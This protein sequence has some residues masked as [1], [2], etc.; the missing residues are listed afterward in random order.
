MGDSVATLLLE[1]CEDD[2]HTPEME[3]KESTGTPE[4][5]EFNR[6]GQ[7]TLHWSVFYIIRKLSKCKCRKWAPMSHLDIYN[8][9]Y[10]K[11]KVGSQTGNLTP[12][13]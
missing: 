9:S 8:T 13:H 6:K 7:N 5:S 11:K 1:E 3:I 10:G 12:D 4:T 2:T